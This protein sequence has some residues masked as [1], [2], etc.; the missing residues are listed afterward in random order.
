[1]TDAPR[2]D[3]HASIAFQLGADLISDDAQ[4]I[5]ELVKNSYD[6]DA[7]FV[8]IE[9]STSGSP[10]VAVAASL[11][12]DAKGYIRIR[13]DGIGMDRDAIRRGWLMVSHSIKREQKATGKVATKRVPLGD[14]GLGRLG[15]QRLADRVELFTKPAVARTETHVAFRWSEF[16]KTEALSQ[17]PVFVA[18]H[19][20]ELRQGTTILLSQLRDPERWASKQTRDLIR[21]RLSELIS[22]FEEIKNFTIHV[23]LDGEVIEVASLSRQLR[24]E[25]DS[26]FRIRFDGDTLLVECKVKLQLLEPAGEHR[27]QQFREKVMGDNGSALFDF[28]RA[29][30]E[31]KNS[32]FSIVAGSGPWFAKLTQKVDLA[33]LD[34]AAKVPGEGTIASPGPFRGEVDSFDFSHEPETSAFGN[35]KAFRNYVREMAGVRVFRDGFGVRVDADFLQ[36]A[37]AW[38]HGRSWYGLK[39]ANTI[40]FIAISAADN[41]QLVE[42]TDREGFTRN[43]YYENF[44]LLL[45]EFV[46][47]SAKA[48]EFVRRGVLRF[49]AP[50]ILDS[51]SDGGPEAASSALGA[52]FKEARDASSAITDLRRTSAEGSRAIRLAAQQLRSSSSSPTANG[53]S[54]LGQS[55][56]AIEQTHVKLDASIERLDALVSGIARGQAQL[57]ILN[58]EIA[59]LREH[60]RRTLDAVGL[61]T[62]AEALVHEIAQVCAGLAKRTSEIQK[63]CKGRVDD[64]KISAFLRH[65]ESAIVALNRQLS[66]IEPSLRYA[67]EKREL[68]QV[69]E[70]LESLAEFH[71]GR[72]VNGQIRMS[73]MNSSDSSL[74]VEMNR[75]KLTQIFDNLIY[76]SEHWLGESLR[77]GRIDRGQIKANVGLNT[78]AFSDNGPGIEPAIEQTLFEPFVSKKRGGRGLGL[79]IVRELLAGEGGAVRLLPKRNSHDR[80]YIIELDFSGVGD[81]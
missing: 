29:S 16:A 27:K 60:V 5:L 35:R 71:N 72:W 7:T 73:V 76:N 74:T 62:T 20:S 2:F 23:S 18:D 41:R 45:R 65:V 32:A 26:T 58:D 53:G 37:K 9:I 75:G 64:E 56:T 38:T 14:K 42:T 30:E 50:F 1:M 69:A 40:G 34:S 61:A 24:K 8:S 47:F 36:L 52:R 25:A 15:T 44:E 10:C 22:P 4:A 55:L 17:V 3:V 54:A 80:R 48:L 12:A 49:L 77:L 28:L 59:G 81:G 67:R 46:D 63:Y 43:S 57:E 6:A 70:F 66:H 19:P 11:N 33:M 39:P 31:A 68:I 79:F 51:D 21:T 13:D 78:V